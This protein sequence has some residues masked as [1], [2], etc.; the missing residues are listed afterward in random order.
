MSRAPDGV[1][2]A[3]RLRTALS[4]LKT[5]RIEVAIFAF[6]VLLRASMSW[7]Y[8]AEWGYDAFNHWE[9]VEWMLRH[10][11]VPPPDAVRSAFHPPLYYSLAAFLFNL[12]VSRAAMVWLSIL[13]GGIRL[14]LI[15]AGLELF[16]PRWRI[17]R[18][19]A[20]FLAGVIGASV[21]IDGMVYPEAMSGMWNAAIM[22]ITAIVLRRT[23]DR[24]WRLCVL[25]GVCMGLAMLTKVSALVTIAALCAAAAFELSFLRRPF[26][27]RLRVAAQ[28]GVAL[29]LCISICGWYFARN[30]H[31]HGQPFVTSFELKAERFVVEGPQ[32]T[33][34]WDRRS[35]GFLTNWDT[36]LY[37]FPYFP[38]AIDAK[39]RIWPAAV[40]SSFIDFYNYSFSGI[41]P[42]QKSVVRALFCPLSTE[43]IAVSRYAMFGATI[44]AAGTVVAWLSCFGWALFRPDFSAA[45][46]LSVASA[47]ALA[48]LH[49]AIKYPV[50]NYGV[51]KGVYMTFGAP[52]MYA[53]FG[54]AVHWASR[55][56]PRWP[57]MALFLASLWLVTSYTVYCRLRIPLVPISWMVR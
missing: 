49:F 41:N 13:F 44:I 27:Q 32:K 43:V 31:D 21:H 7:S 53:L 2:S 5:R 50:D 26:K 51:I 18:V 42:N 34:Y 3:N 14:L 40:A 54:V 25:L 16:L 57:L 8:K 15:W 47:T 56:V 24:R 22:L 20:L 48:A 12:G 4:W 19:A 38:T 30:V 46:L 28:W 45:F 23:P 33:P 6:A 36:R 39:P 35:I 52:P 55:R 10:H 37:Y 29:V 1:P 17:A 11:A 9:V